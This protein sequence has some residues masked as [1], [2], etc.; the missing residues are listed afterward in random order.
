MKIKRKNY[1]L[2]IEDIFLDGFAKKRAKEELSEDIRLEK[3]LGM[4]NFFV[5][6]ALVFFVLFFLLV[7]AF[8]IQTKD[9]E[10]FQGL[11]EKNKSVS[12]RFSSQRGIIYD[13]NMTQLVE[14][15]ASFDLFFKPLNVEKDNSEGAVIKKI[16]LFLSKSPQEVQDIISTTSSLDLEGSILLKKNLSQQDLVL[17]EGAKDSSPFLEV[18]KRILR[19]YEQDACLSHLLGYLGKITQEEFASSSGY[20]INDYLGR[21]GLEGFYENILKET[22][23]E[24]KIQRNALGQELARETVSLPKSGESVIL[25]IDLALQK[26]SV[27]VL[28]NVLSEIGS[29]KG[30]VLAIDPRDGGVLA[31]ISLPCYD[32]NLFS[33]GIS[34]EAWEKLTQDKLNPQLNR[35]ISGLY[36]TGSTIKPFVALGALNEGIVK[37]NTSFY[38]PQKICIENQYNKQLA[39]CFVDWTFHGW[40]DVK[41]AL[42]ESVNPFFYLVSGGYTPP[43]PSSEYYIPELSKN[44]KGMGALKLA[45]YLEMF[46]FSTTTG[47]DLLSEGHG[48]VPTPEWKQSYFTT[49]T[50]QQWYLG[51]TYNMSIGQGFLLATP[52]EVASAF[53]GLVNNGKFIVP[54]LLKKELVVSKQIEGVAVEN[55]DIVKRGMRQCVVSGSCAR[56]RNLPFTVAAKTGTAQTISKA[57]I[58]DNWVAAFAPYENPEIVLVVLLEDVQGVR[59][60]A[61]TVAEQILYWYFVENK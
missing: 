49:K 57:D 29:Q 33:A 12:L 4:T 9:R 60:A 59:V 53:T 5:F 32:N 58:Y 43:K 51:D 48:R 2:N 36:P 27:E 20:Y 31:M 35:A 41:R 40:T 13:R 39:E 30:V 55:Y 10:Y 25:T 37:E 22:K 44:I 16:N 28:G 1:E 54:H 15:E 45:Q 56:F 61:Q 17:F 11:A 34:S 52:I 7:F 42:A 14:N 6:N 47:I 24:V 8:K 23:G 38:C 19:K 46:G 18:R 26:K 3:P 21:A 50:G